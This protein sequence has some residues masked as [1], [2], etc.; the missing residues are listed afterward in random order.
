MSY[1]FPISFMLNTFSMTALLVALSLVGKS[2]IAADVGIVQGA[3]LA[4]FYAFSANARNMILNP[5][6]RISARAILVA[7]Y[8]LLQWLY[9]VLTAPF[10]S[11]RDSSVLWA[12]DL[13]GGCRWRHLRLHRPMRRT[14]NVLALGQ[15]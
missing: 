6:F 1:L 15:R 14:G 4:L 7:V 11:F 2:T 10:P 12:K 13:R 8:S 9:R 5:S 3:T